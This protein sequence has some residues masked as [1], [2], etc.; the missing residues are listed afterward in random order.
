MNVSG[1]DNSLT[2]DVMQINNYIVIALNSISKYFILEKRLLFSTNEKNFECKA[3]RI[4][5]TG[6]R[7][8]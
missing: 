2:D 6:K 4:N 7:Y 5:K 3:K 8:C 1:N